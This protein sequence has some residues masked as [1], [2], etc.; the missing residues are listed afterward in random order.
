MTAEFTV[1]RVCTKK[2]YINDEVCG[3]TK[4]KR[5]TRR[6]RL[7]SALYLMFKKRKIHFFLKKNEFFELFSSRKCHIVPENVK[8]GP[9]GLY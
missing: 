1:N 7:K 3:L 5:K 8:G 6:E 9:F 2:W 4:K